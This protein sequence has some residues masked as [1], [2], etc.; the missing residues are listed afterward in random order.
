[1][2]FVKCEKCGK[3]HS[4]KAPECPFCKEDK[5]DVQILKGLSFII[6][7]AVLVSSV[8][9]S[10]KKEQD[11]KQK[12][13]ESAKI[14]KERRREESRRRSAEATAKRN[15]E[16]AKKNN[17]PVFVKYGDKPIIGWKSCAE[18][19]VYL[20]RVANDPSSVSMVGCSEPY[21]RDEGW[22]VGC[23]FRAKNAFGAL[24][25]KGAIFTIKHGQVVSYNEL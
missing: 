18:V 7:I 24:I 4:E 9:V 10:H 6:I 15:E 25:K 23:E 16:L 1:M 21:L 5:N 3:K 17:D 8:Y 22:I 2:A 12:A 11:L 19:D 13:I 20:K 14:E